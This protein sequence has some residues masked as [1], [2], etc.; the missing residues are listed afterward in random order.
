MGKFV[1]GVKGV[2]IYERGVDFPKRKVLL[3][4]LRS[5][6]WLTSSPLLPPG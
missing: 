1:D 2:L 5:G 3:I 4:L 6:L